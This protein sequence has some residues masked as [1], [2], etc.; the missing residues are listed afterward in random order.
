[1]SS[2]RNK[3]RQPAPAE[4]NPSPLLARSASEGDCPSLALRANSGATAAK[5][6]IGLLGGIGSGKSQVA[7]LLSRHGGRVIDADQLGHQALRQPDILHRVVQRW[8]ARLLDEQGQI[9]RRRLAA[10]VFGDPAERQ[11]LEE[12]VHPW[13]GQAIREEIARAQTDPAIRFIVLDAAVMLEAGWHTVCQKLLF[14]DVPWQLR[15]ERLTH[16][17]GWSAQ[18]AAGP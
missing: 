12:I 4:G 15:L 8:G 16:Q 14:V 2:P 3:Q 11:A 9:V 18:Q 5:P 10:I 6:V 13:I 1:M 7:A 17:R